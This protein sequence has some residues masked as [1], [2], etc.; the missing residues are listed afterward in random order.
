MILDKNLP[1][2]AQAPE[3]L[4]YRDAW[5]PGVDAPW[6]L[7]NFRFMPL[8]QL[9]SRLTL[10]SQFPG[11]RPK[12]LEVPRCPQVLPL[13]FPRLLHAFFQEDVASQR[14]GPPGNF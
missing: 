5:T 12:T 14:A 1:S 9:S 2:W 6:R 7:S 4:G 10:N 11:L 8:S 13:P 3:V